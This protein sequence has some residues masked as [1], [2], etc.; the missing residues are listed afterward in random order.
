[1]SA[2]LSL[3]ANVILLASLLAL[4]NGLLKWVAQKE[5][6]NYLEMVMTYWLQI[7]ASLAI[8]GFIFFYYIQVLRRQDI[9]VFYSAYVG[10]SILM[11][12][13]MGTFFFG[14]NLSLG[15]IGGVALVILGIICIGML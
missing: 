8:Y 3:I 5:V 6:A 14:E 12:F 10:L 13:L 2:R 9:A 11:V 1:M 15:Q 7:G 4:A